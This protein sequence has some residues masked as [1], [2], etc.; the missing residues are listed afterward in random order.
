[1]RAQIQ[2]EA[3]LL[4][5]QH[6]QAGTLL[7]ECNPPLPPEADPCTGAVGREDCRRRP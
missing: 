6:L 1:M 2:R 4:R 7:P 3:I 5:A